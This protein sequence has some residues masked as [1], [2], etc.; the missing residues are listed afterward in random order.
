[1][2]SALGRRGTSRGA[3]L[4]IYHRVGGGSPDER[5]VGTAQFEQQ[6]DLLATMAEVLCLDDAL[7]RLATGD[8]SPSV[9]LTFDDGFE[10]VY[11]NAWPLLKARGLPFVV[12]LCS[13]F[14][15]GTMHWD[16]S[17]AKAAGPAL[18]WDQLGEMVATGLCTVGNHTTTHCVPHRLTTDELDRCTQEIEEHLGV[19]P[20]HFAWTWGVP[21]PALQDQLAERFRSCATGIVGR[22]L[23]GC[24]PHVLERIPVRGTDPLPFFEAKVTGSL[25]PELTYDRI[26][27]AAK[28]VGLRA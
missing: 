22:N 7:E 20:R 6:L 10:D 18:T 19:T 2:L 28:K 1:M 15:G 14:V 24:D 11:R 26:V 17:T 16:G 21:V 9:V 8:P 27:S 12:Y 23:P 25:L 13:S 5:D 4:L 3:S